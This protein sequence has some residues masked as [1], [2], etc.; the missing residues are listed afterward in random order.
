MVIDI[1]EA[2]HDGCDLYQSPL[3]IE[4]NGRNGV[5]HWM[6]FLQCAVNS[7]DR[8]YPMADALLAALDRQVRAGDYAYELNDF[9]VRFVPS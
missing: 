7:E 3:E 2:T 9:V 8:P 6:H 1:L 5:G 4:Q